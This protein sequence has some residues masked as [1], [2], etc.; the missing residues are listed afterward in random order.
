MRKWSTTKELADLI[1]AKANAGKTVTLS[2]DTALFAGMN[3]ERVDAKPS[4][5]EVA[6]LLCTSKSKCSEPCTGC[7]GKANPIVR[8]YG[9]RLE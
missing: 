4:R 6:L 5:R 7:I 2:P 8:V 9:Q 1:L 3:L